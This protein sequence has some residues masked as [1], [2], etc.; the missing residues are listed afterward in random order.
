MEAEAEA[1]T[2]GTQRKQW[3]QY[4]DEMVRPKGPRNP[5]LSAKRLTAHP[6][7]SSLSL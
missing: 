3:T 7:L 5:R 6:R 2:A 4:E 1:E